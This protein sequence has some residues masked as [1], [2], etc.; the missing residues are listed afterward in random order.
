MCI[1]SIFRQTPW[2]P[3]Y[4]KARAWESLTCYG[5]ILAQVPTVRSTSRVTWFETPRVW[6]RTPSGYPTSTGY[7]LHWN[8]KHQIYQVVLKSLHTLY[9]GNFLIQNKTTLLTTTTIMSCNIIAL[10][11]NSPWHL[12]ILVTNHAIFLLISYRKVWPPH[13]IE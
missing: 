7:L 8:M 6:Y 10:Q 11:Q 2:I 3:L 4:C 9:I 1:I 12:Q 13:G 5:I